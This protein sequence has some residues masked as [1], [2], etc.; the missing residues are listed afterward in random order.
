M[1]IARIL[2]LVT[3]VATLLLLGDR[4]SAQSKSK[5]IETLYEEAVGL[6]ATGQVNEAVA[7]FQKMI[8]V[9]KGTETFYEDYGAQA[10]G[11]MFDYGMALLMSSHWEEAKEAFTT[12]INSDKIATD[13]QTPVKSTN[14]RGNLAKFQLGYCEAQLGNHEEALKLYDEYLAGN[15][16]QEEV[17]QVRNPYKLRYATSLI[18]LG[19]MDEGLPLVQELFDNREDWNVDPQFLMQG[20]LESGMA[21]VAEATDVTMDRDAIEK[22]S[23]R[24]QEFLDT[25]EEAIHVVPFDQ[26]R[27]GFVERLRKLGFEST[28]V[29]LYALALRYFSYVPT[30]QDIRD[31]INL[32][33]ARRPVGNP[34]PSQIQAALD[35]LD[36]QEKAEVSPDLEM[37]RLIA[38]CYEH[39][40]NFRAPRAINWYLAT[41]FP[42]LPAQSKTEVLHE[43]SRLSAVLGDYNGSEFFGQKFMAESSADSPLRTNV[44]SFMLQSLFTSNKYDEVIKVAEDVRKAHQPGAAE[45]ELADALYPLALYATKKYAEAEEPFAEYVKS[46]AEGNNRETIMYHRA[47]NSLVLRKMREAAEQCEDFLS[48]YPTSE[49]F[50]DAVI[51]DLVVARFNLGDFPAAIAAAEKLAAERPNSPHLARAENL[52]GDSLLLEAGNLP[53]EEAEQAEEKK[54]TALAAYLAAVEAG[55]AAEKSDAKNAVA[56]KESVGEAL[57]KSTDLYYKNEE[58][59]KGLAQYDDFIAGYTG[60]FFEPQISVFSLPHLEEKGRGDE[61]LAQVEKVI[62][63][64]G[65][66]PPG[67]QDVELLRQCIGSYSEASV[68][69][70]G[71]DSTLARLNDFPGVQPS[72]QAMHTWLKI[73]Q[74]IVL[75]GSRKG[76]AK[77]APE[78]AA[79]E[80]KIA[81]VFEELRK[82]EKRDL[83]E[84]AL[85]QI[86]LY[87]SSTD[88][89]FLG[90]PYFEELLARTSPEATAFKAPAEMELGKIEMRAADPGKVQAAR[91]RFRRVIADNS[92]DALPLHGQAYLNLADLFMANKEWKDALGA[93]D[94]INKDKSLFVTNK[95]KR[96]EATFKLG[97]VY[98]ALGD[99]IAANQAYINVV[100]AYSAFRDWLTQAWERYIPNSLAEIEKL[101]ETD[102]LSIALKRKRVLALYKL[103]V[104]Y[105]YEWQKL[106]EERDA[107]SGALARL[108]R[109]V[110]ELKNELK[111]TPQEE[112]D[113]LRDLGIAQTN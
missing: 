69:L 71:V 28:K 82:F 4:A 104:K 33:M 3:S 29:G 10:G 106:D 26:F 113:I 18:R 20:V 43:A 19:R 45:R 94:A 21:W 78:Y 62:V 27:F 92:E 60:T 77:D 22:I 24:A 100:G 107:P 103:C 14:P 88:N 50:L 108:R 74:V 11:I 97:V 76:I 56:H 42:E 32:N 15:P 44:S 34:I 6:T 38:S 67:M 80:S 112:Q 66:R 91:E 13:V 41:N 84:Y 96:A 85:Q 64:V 90:V 99:P 5:E 36:K 65:A 63:A 70:R 51:S 53:Q 95:A 83:T 8:E 25:N 2:I 109:R 81:A 110:P 101:P 98:D 31:D 1:K 68:R 105:L 87:F 9:A 23:D 39:L 47:S 75:Q 35:E 111:I 12:C 79:I 37:L 72:D 52:R 93:L 16:P 49:R 86:G 102:P 61:A 89:P 40:G 7:A 73:Q 58:I 46:Y 59:D 17:T 30:I 54:K 55:K 57:W 48:A